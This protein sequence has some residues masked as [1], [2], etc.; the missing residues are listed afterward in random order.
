MAEVDVGA[1]AGER[2]AQIAELKRLGGEQG[3]R[4][5]RLTAAL[6][7]LDAV[8]PRLQCNAQRRHKL[9]TRED[10]DQANVTEAVDSNA[11][12]SP[13]APTLGIH[14][15]QAEAGGVVSDSAS[16]A[17]TNRKTSVAD[18]LSDVR[19]IAAASMAISDSSGSSS[20]G[21]FADTGLRGSGRVNHG[22]LPRA[23]RP[24]LRFCDTLTTAQIGRILS[25][26]VMAHNGI[27]IVEDGGREHHALQIS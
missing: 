18:G 27:H 17:A 15:D 4:L 1:L 14:S 11:A 26:D 6:D 3:D 8:E 7:M 10:Q 21:D 25:M 2:R 13:C 23:L 19:N 12:S 16:D 22:R 24:Y 20:S 5:A 9:G